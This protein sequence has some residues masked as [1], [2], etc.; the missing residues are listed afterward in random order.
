MKMIRIE[1]PDKK[2]LLERI[3]DLVVEDMI[4]WSIPDGIDD[5][6]YN[7]NFNGAA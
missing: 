6:I 1:V 4:D 7:E 2:E 5:D 3:R